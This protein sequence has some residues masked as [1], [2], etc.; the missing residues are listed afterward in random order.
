M[1]SI[2]GDLIMKKAILIYL[3][4]FLIMSTTLFAEENN[5]KKPIIAITTFESKNVSADDIEFVMHVFTAEFTRLGVATVVDRKY[6]DKIIEEQSFQISD[7]ADKNKVAE[8][9]KALGAN[10]LV[11]GRLVRRG[12]FFFLTI[13][14]LNVKTTTIVAAHLDRAKKIDDFFDKMPEFCAKLLESAN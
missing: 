9:G 11:V 14:I 8:L 6:F 10:H 13:K 7:W 1:P 3:C 5:V 2:L 4:I 12:S